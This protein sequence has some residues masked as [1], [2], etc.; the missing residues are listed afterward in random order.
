MLDKLPFQGQIAVFSA[1]ALAVVIAAYY[2][3]PGLGEMRTEIAGLE[4]QFADKQREILKGQ[5]IE[6]RL[7][8]FEREIANL[9]AKLRDIQQ[10]LPTD[11]EAGELLRWIKNLGDQSNLDL[12]SFAPGGLRPAEFYKE[13]PIEMQVVGRYHDL[14]IFLDRVSK[15]SRIINVDNLRIG[16]VR[17]KGK[18]IQAS[19]TA[20]T[21]VYSGSEEDGQ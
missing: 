6:Q 10:I 9:E 13:F 21:F 3:Y 11:R 14:G 20:T 15:Y 18:S 8:D 16:A 17:E 7:P 12:K 19:L 2:V 1:L 4:E 5:A